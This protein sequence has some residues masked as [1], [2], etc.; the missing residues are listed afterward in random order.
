MR[1]AASVLRM[2][3]MGGGLWGRMEVPCMPKGSDSIFREEECECTGGCRLQV[4]VTALAE[5]GSTGTGR[6]GGR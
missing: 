2:R 3:K 5:E 4:E 1:T 6:R